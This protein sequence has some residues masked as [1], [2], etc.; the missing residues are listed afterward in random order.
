MYLRKWEENWSIIPGIENSAIEKE[1]NSWLIQ[2]HRTVS[3]RQRKRDDAYT[4]N[5]FSC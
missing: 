5:K 3:I 1:I 4:G 2:I